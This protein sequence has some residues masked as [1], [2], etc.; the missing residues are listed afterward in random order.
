M[1]GKGSKTVVTKT[2][3]HVLKKIEDIVRKAVEER[4]AGELSLTPYP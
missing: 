3:K 2:P 1:S 4:F